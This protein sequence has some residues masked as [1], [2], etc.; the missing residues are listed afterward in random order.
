MDKEPI[1]DPTTPGTPERHPLHAAM[2]GYYPEK[3]YPD[4]TSVMDDAHSKIGELDNYKQE[5]EAAN[6]QII[7]AV[8]S[9]PVLGAVISDVIKG[10]TFRAAI[11]RH[12]DPEDLAGEHGDPDFE[13]IETN[14][15][16]RLSKKSE[17]ET[18]L[19]ELQQNIQASQEEIKGFAEDNGMTEEDAASF[20]TNVTSVLEDAY[21]GKITKDFLARM[22]TA[23]N[24]EKEVAAAAENGVIEGKNMA[25]DE[26]KELNSSAKAGD[27]LPQI[28]A[29]ANKQAPEA[30]KSKT[31]GGRFLA[32]TGL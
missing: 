23:E 19:Q 8:E 22:Y 6:Q 3:D 7:D 2:K 9:E 27:G 20:L 32:G 14:R 1:T 29:G 5:N 28:T 16:E 24:H 31:I 10:M 17:N 4:D 18:F 12:F 11:A 21:K 25:I 13:S 30:P 26:K 15:Q